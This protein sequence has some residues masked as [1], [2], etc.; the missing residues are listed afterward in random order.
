ML[1]RIAATLKEKGDDALLSQDLKRAAMQRVFGFEIMPAPFVVSHLQLGLML[2]HLGAPLSEKTSERVGVYLTN[3]L[4]G[5]E[6]PT[7]ESKRKYAL[8]DQAFPPL[9]EER[10]ASEKVKRDTPILVILGNPPYNG[11]AGVAMAG[12]KATERE[13]TLTKEERSLTEAYRT[14]KKA[15]AP[16]GEGLNDLANIIRHLYRPFD[17]RWLYWE[18]ETKLIDEKSAPPVGVPIRPML[19]APSSCRAEGC[20]ASPGVIAALRRIPVVQSID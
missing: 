8:L 18:P 15:P 7:E 1:K 20:A 14:T 19:P 17:V 16:Q 10:E 5:W 12:D 3:S 4:T 11:Y 6:P 2:Q 9:K 13:R